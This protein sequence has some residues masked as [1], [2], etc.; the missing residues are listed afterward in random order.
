GGRDDLPWPELNQRLP[1]CVLPGAGA[2]RGDVSLTRRALASYL[3]RVTERMEACAGSRWLAVT[4]LTE[5]AGLLEW[6][7]P[8]W[9]GGYVEI[10]SSDL[11]DKPVEL[12]AWPRRR[13]NLSMLQRSLRYL[14]GL[15]KVDWRGIRGIGALWTVKGPDLALAKHRKVSVGQ[16]WNCYATTATVGWTLMRRVSFPLAE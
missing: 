7:G 13:P 11:R 4:A 10:V 14:R 8:L 3:H 12:A 5:V 16:L 15:W 9:V 6:L 2:G 1:V